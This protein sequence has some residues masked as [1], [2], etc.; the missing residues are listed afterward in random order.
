MNQETVWMTGVDASINGR[1]QCKD[2]GIW[3]SY[4]SPQHFEIR[5]G[6]PR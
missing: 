6:G 2:W 4:C 1:L 5:I 3:T